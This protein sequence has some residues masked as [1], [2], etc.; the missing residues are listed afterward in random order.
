MTRKSYFVKIVDQFI[1]IY[2]ILLGQVMGYQAKEEEEML[3]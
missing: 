2:I 3:V 1:E